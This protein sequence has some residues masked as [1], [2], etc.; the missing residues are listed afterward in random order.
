MKTVQDKDGNII[1]VTDDTMCHAGKNGAL[2][3]MLDDE[4][5]AIAKAELKAHADAWEAGAVERNAKAEISKLESQITPRRIRD[6][7]LG[8][9]NGWLTNQ[10]SLIAIERNK[11]GE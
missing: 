1:E 8:T 11:L 9:D 2:P 3:V 10:E 4:E 6:A 7:V 5:L